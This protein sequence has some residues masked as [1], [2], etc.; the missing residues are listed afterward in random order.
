VLAPYRSASE[1][2][3]H[4]GA[5]ITLQ[6]SRWEFSLFASGNQLIPIS[7]LILLVMIVVYID[8]YIRIP[9]EQK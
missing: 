3:F 9:P 6:K 7:T 8:A 1:A 2:G 5:G 4:R